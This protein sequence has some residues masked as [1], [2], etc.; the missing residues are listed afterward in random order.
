M[1]LEIGNGKLRLPAPCKWTLDIA[2]GE[3]K[4]VP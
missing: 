3:A 2:T 1:P 4:I